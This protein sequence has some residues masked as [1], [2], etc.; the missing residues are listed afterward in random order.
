MFFMA[1]HDKAFMAN[2]G[3]LM[4]NY[5]KSDDARTTPRSG[6][7]GYYAYRA[8]LAAC[9]KIEMLLRGSYFEVSIID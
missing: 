3:E 7:S 2:C 8:S 1:Y 6:V 9:P 4:W 5:A